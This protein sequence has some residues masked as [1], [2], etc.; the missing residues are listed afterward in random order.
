MEIPVERY[1]EVPTEVYR[2]KIIELKKTEC[3]L[4]TIDRYIE[5]SGSKVINLKNEKLKRD[6]AA[7]KNKIHQ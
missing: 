1:V 6:I 3:V 5:D 2:D 7:N 4:H